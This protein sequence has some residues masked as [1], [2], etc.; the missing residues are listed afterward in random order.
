MTGSRELIQLVKLSGS[1][2]GDES[3]QVGILQADAMH[4]KPCTT[5]GGGGLLVTVEVTKQ[6]TGTLLGWDVR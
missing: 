2:H 5:R 4:H 3:L 6:V 1:G